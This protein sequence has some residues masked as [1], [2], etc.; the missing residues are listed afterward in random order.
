MS[1]IKSVTLY[2]FLILLLSVS[3]VHA[4]WLPWGNSAL[5]SV[6]G[7][8]YSGD[9]FRV[10]WENLREKDMVLP[11]TPDPFVDWI[12]MF[13]EAER[14]QLYQDQEYRKKVLT[15]LKART[16]ILLKAEE[17]DS[18]I[19]ISDQDL[20]VRYQRDFTPVFQVNLL[21]FS[22][23]EAADNLR[24]QFGGRPVDEE[25]FKD[26]A[27]G[28][29]GLLSIRTQAYRPG[30]IDPGW[31]EILDRLE[32]GGMSQ[33]M[34]WKK[35]FVVLRLQ[36]KTEGSADDFEL[37]RRQI[38]QSLWKERQADLTIR[39][40]QELRRKYEVKVHQDRLQQ[41][42]ITRSDD[43]FSNEPIVT[44]THGLVSEKEFMIQV[45]RMQRFRRQNGFS[46]DNSE[47]FKQRV[48]NG[49]IDQTLTSWEARARQYETK[50]PFK[51]TYT[52]YCRHRMIKA[53]EGRIFLP[54][55]EVRPG[56]IKDYY[57]Q[58]IQE[59]TLPETI[60]MVIAEGSEQE[61]NGLWTE[62]A[63]GGDFM[64]LARKR[65]GLKLPV[66][67]IPADHLQ[68]QVYEVV[69]RLSKGELSPVFTVDGHVTLVQLVERR[70]ARV[71]PL[72]MV[73]SRIGEK[74]QKQRLA[75]VREEFL[76]RLR[77]QSTI[78]ID[79]DMWQQLKKEME[80]LDEE[81]TL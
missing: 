38:R 76:I 53:L 7:Q 58:H 46:E 31:R 54:Q 75:T 68:K 16:L 27:S 28:Q 79:N 14:M 22:N 44:T 42:D 60:R 23:R 57:Q 11:E 30:F 70:P 51:D 80:Q 15:F 40:L 1:Q 32:K 21:F 13:R 78:Q 34:A 20:R 67:E 19:S 73:G 48:V 29:N 41:L 8:E 56:D 72:D 6:D 43:S 36:E 17:V 45:R 65:L 47:T 2:F 3:F 55:A 50:P 62:V 12:L 59:F 81:K 4:G 10:W 64:L 74:L 33:P 61:M 77:E 5:V 69:S 49:I 35:G 26:V 37:V 66:R 71:Q 39:L 24:Q 25:Q 63:M 9:D 18:K 52:Y